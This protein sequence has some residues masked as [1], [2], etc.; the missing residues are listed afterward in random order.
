M[1]NNIAKILGVVLTVVT[2]ASVLVVAGPTSAAPAAQAW[3]KY[4]IPSTTGMVLNTTIDVGGPI[5]QAFDSSAL[6]AYVHTTTPAFM[7][8]KSTD[9]GR[10]WKNVVAS[11]APTAAVLEIVCSPTEANVVFYITAA[12]LF[13]STDSGVNFTAIV[14]APTG[15]AFTALDAAKWSGRYIAVVGT[16]MAAVGDA[17]VF[18][19]D[20]SLPFNN[21]TPVGT[22]AFSS[23]IATGAVLSVKMAP[24]FATDRVV[25]AVGAN[26]TTNAT[27][28]RMDVNGGAWG[29]TVADVA[30][31]G[32]VAD[33]TAA[34]IA[35]PSDFN[36][37][38]SPIYF[39]C[40]ADATVADGGVY[41]V[42]GNVATR[43][44]STVTD[45]NMSYS[46]SFASGTGTLLVGTTAGTAVVNATSGN[47]TYTA[48]SLRSSAAVTAWVLLDRA[49]AT[50]KLAWILNVGALNG[51]LNVTTDAA[52]YNQWSL[53]NET[54]AAAA[55]IVDLAVAP[56]G[57]V[58]MLT[59]N[60]AGTDTS[61][62]RQLNSASTPWE[63]VLW[64]LTAPAAYANHI[65]LAA[66][67]A[68]GKD[69]AIWF[70]TQA[71]AG[72]KVSTN[73]ANKFTAMTTAP[74]SIVGGI[75]PVY[76]LYLINATTAVVG[77]NDGTIVTNQT[78]T[79]VTS[80]YWW[81]EVLQTPFGAGYT[82]NQI[83]NA[84]G[85][86]LLA[87]AVSAAGTTV[88]V[89]KSADNGLTWTVLTATI[90]VTAGPAFIAPADDYA[91]TG[92]L[93]VA[94]TPGVWM[95]PSATSTFV[96]VDNGTASV[97]SG[98]TAD[99]VPVA[100][101]LVAV[102]AANT[103][104]EGTGVIY[105]TD[106]TATANNV[107][108]IRGHQT[109]SEKLVPAIIA[110][111]TFRGIWAGPVAAGSIQLWTLDDTATAIWNY[112][113]TLA[114][115]GTGVTVSNVSTNSGGLFGII[116]ASTSAT[117][118]WTALTNATGYVVFVNSVPQTKLY[119]AAND[120]L[121]ATIA[122][123]PAPVV[124][125]TAGTTALVSNMAPGVTY[126]VSIW[127]NAPVSSFMFGATIA[128]PLP[129]PTAAVPL[130]PTLG[131]ED[132][133]LQPGFAWAAVNGATSYS[134]QLTLASDTAYASPVINVTNIPAVIGQPTVT[135]NWNGAAL[136]NNTS[137][138]WRVAANLTGGG[139]SAWVLGNFRTEKVVTPPV[140]VTTQ[141][142][143]TIIFPTAQP[144]VTV[145]INPA[146]PAPILTVTQ[147]IITLTTPPAG[148]TPS[149]IWIIVGVGA[150]LT[151]A[152][153]ILII[154]TRRVV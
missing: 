29:A 45:S 10:T 26:T 48:V 78:S 106:G 130:V 88:K 120:L 74:G 40:V 79:G 124:V 19:W 52:T 123:V 135:Y 17:G 101:G 18:Y 11:G 31:I 55:G 75:N 5:A 35:F 80:A 41:R 98:V 36:Y 59:V 122:G 153:I 20:Q 1:K 15:D 77:D 69:L 94:G 150:V 137:Y 70:T 149:Y 71:A 83:V 140:T 65:T 112:V 6:Y 46:G 34:D 81:N 90:T 3:S 121:G 93:Y 16:N 9:N 95:Y 8:I 100:A 42:I 139:N 22:T 37:A 113:D 132:V 64:S 142:Q 108:R 109:V 118:T 39:V 63:R 147:P 68:T 13:M 134:L 58:F 49:Y 67:Y 47:G 117:V 82:V 104:A 129:P 99:A 91:T 30:A 72:V 76:S 146:P 138:I 25:V 2:L 141:P 66:D 62:W 14:N 84:G 107:A 143:P 56:N 44:E 133:D 61:L 7:L 89:A 43:V 54:I 136:T 4:S 105:A 144:P 111:D 53:I 96:R 126:N 85:S 32:T 57:D 127:A 38:T 50:S 102:S 92:A 115:Q 33:A 103:S 148:P 51:A 73:N 27:I 151:I 60:T 125:A 110:A 119:T 116:G 131:A 128:A 28:I 86:N 145:T 97:A 154:R 114:V 87:V 24:T 21:L 152:V 23:G 12:T